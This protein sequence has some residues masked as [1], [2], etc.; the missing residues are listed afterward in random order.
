MKAWWFEMK[1]R[2]KLVDHEITLKILE[3]ALNSIEK[4]RPSF[5]LQYVYFLNWTGQNPNL[6]T[7]TSKIQVFCRPEWA[8]ELTPW[9]WIL[10]IFKWKND[11]PKQL[12]LE[13]QMK[14]MGSFARFSYLLSELWSLNCQKLCPFC[15]FCWCRQQI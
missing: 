11:F 9:K 3:F 14:K 15:I 5:F 6:T 8:K 1:A 2:R 13:K 10:T 12:G 7:F 4:V